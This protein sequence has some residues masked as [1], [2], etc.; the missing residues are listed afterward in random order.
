MG[1]E[2]E[3]YAY[4]DEKRIDQTYHLS[5]LALVMMVRRR[6]AAVVLVCKEHIIFGALLPGSSFSCVS[7]HRPDF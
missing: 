1:M 2:M 5:C 4:R 7:K 6:L 3:I